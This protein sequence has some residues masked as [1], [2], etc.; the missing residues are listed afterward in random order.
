MR[1]P[2]SYFHG[3]EGVAE[4]PAHLPAERG[5]LVRLA[6]DTGA[7]LRFGEQ[8]LELLEEEPHMVAGE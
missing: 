4:C 3:R 1:C 6:G 5:W 8:H 7:P 2:T